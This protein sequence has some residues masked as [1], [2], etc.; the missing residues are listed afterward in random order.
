MAVGAKRLARRTQRWVAGAIAASLLLSFTVTSTAA[1][2]DEDDQLEARK[3]QLTSQIAN[4]QAAVD[5]LEARVANANT[6]VANAQARVAAAQA[7]VAAAREAVA[8]A[9]A[10]DAEMAIALAA[11]EADLDRAEA[12]EARGQQNLAEERDQLAVATAVNFQQ[13]GTLISI[14]SV[15]DFDQSTGDLANRI[16]WAENSIQSSETA[17]ARLEQIQR[18]LMAAREA[19]EIAQARADDAK[20]AAEAHL[21]ETQAAQAA[22][23][24]AEAELQAALAAEQAAQRSAQSAL[25]DAEAE[26]ARIEAERAEVNAEIARRAEEARRAAEAAAAAAAAAANQAAASGPLGLIRPVNGYVT[27]GYGYRYS[28]VYGWYELHDG[29]DFGASCWTPIRAAHSGTVVQS[30]WSTIGFGY[31]IVVEGWWN[32]RYVTT[33][34]NHMAQ[35]GIAAGTY[36]NQGDIIGYVGTTGVSTGCHLHFQL[37]VN[38]TQ[39]DP[40]NWL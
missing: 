17:L 3:N 12:A 19:T 15:L 27:S 36:V 14:A 38:G 35:L 40:M 31:R 32:G 5:G 9:E 28:P 30:T 23:E 25:D 39:V 34:Y 13:S 4:Q 1:A 24:Q 10:H 6:A 18:E 11:A 33:G 20:A 2:D 8:E 37:W 22:A 16:Q 26:L 29:T 7:A 21:A